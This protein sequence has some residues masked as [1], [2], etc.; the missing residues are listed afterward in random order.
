MTDFDIM[1]E[2]LE[3]R[4]KQD[5]KWGEQNHSPEIWSLI[6]T[7]EVGEAAQAMLEAHFNAQVSQRKRGDSRWD[8]ARSELIQVAAVAVAMI[9]SLDRNQRSCPY[10]HGAEVIMTGPNTSEPCVCVSKQFS[11][12]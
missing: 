10:C 12:H 8:D 3:E 6:L 1:Q 4:K 5:E 7:E 9:A 11:N 2:I